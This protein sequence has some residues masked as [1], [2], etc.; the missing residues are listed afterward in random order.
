MLEKKW[1]WK[2]VDKK[3][4]EELANEHNISPFIAELLIKRGIASEDVPAFL[5]PKLEDL[6]SP[7]RL[8]DM[9]KGV[10][11]IKRAIKNKEK[12]LIFGDYDVDG[13]TST[14][15][16]YFGLKELGGEVSYYIPN[17]E[18]G[19]GLNKEALAQAISQ[20]VSLV[21]TVDCGITGLEEVIFCNE[22]GVNCIVTDHHLPP[23]VLPPAFA[24]INPKQKGCNYPFKELAGVGLAF[25]LITA[26]YQTFNKIGWEKYL[27][28]VALGTVADLVPLLGEN[29]TIVSLGLKKMNEDLRMPL[30]KLASVAGV[31]TEIEAYHLGFVFGPRLNAAGRLESPKEAINLLLAQNEEQ[32]LELAKFLDKQNKERQEVEQR[33]LE[34]C[35]QMVDKLNLG[36]T[37]VLVLANED[38]HHGVIGIVASRLVEKYHRPVILLAIKGEEANGSCRSIEGFHIHQALTYCEDLLIKYGGHAMAAGLT[39]NKKYINEFREK[40]NS[41]AVENNIDNYLVPKLYIDATLDPTNLDLKMIGEINKLKPFGQGNPPPVFRIPNLKICKFSLINECHLKVDFKLDHMWLNTIGFKKGDLISRIYGK[42][43]IS[44]AGYLEENNFNGNTSLQMKFIDLKDESFQSQE[45]FIEI[46]DFRK[47]SLKAYFKLVENLG[48]KY[49]LYTNGYYK[50]KLEKFYLEQKNVIIKEYG[51]KIEKGIPVFLHP[52]FKQRDFLQTIRD[53]EE[54]GVE[55]IIIA[56]REDNV[57]LLPDRDFLVALYTAIKKLNNEGKP[58]DINN[59]KIILNDKFSVDYLIHRGLNIFSECNLIYLKKDCWFL[60]DV[61][62]KVDYQKSTTF[63]K[64]SKQ[65]QLFYK[66]HQFA[67]NSSLEDLLENQQFIIEEDKIWI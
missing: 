1:L 56:F 25:K 65:Q 28:L 39:I 10:E 3:Q 9:E 45:R 12:I 11:R 46:L 6:Y 18:E 4:V 15:V 61:Q 27:D 49:I 51:E 35:I 42:K 8:K 60:S 47:R 17:R 36:K 31:T 20:G 13:I 32:A 53:Y 52:P 14:A 7:F 57:L 29:R 55:Q 21:I 24:I 22:Q 50:N 41:Y 54:L 48:K 16:L 5:N 2:E 67:L 38:W 30:K 23:E 63:Q 19:Y 59:I 64:Y 43:H 34:E 44:V 40:I 37:K 66:W 58:A 62:E 26:L 33:I